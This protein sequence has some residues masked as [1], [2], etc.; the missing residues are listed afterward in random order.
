MQ[1]VMM[2]MLWSGPCV[3]IK[4]VSVMW[5]CHQSMSWTA[6]GIISTMEGLDLPS[7]SPSADIKVHPCSP[8]HGDFTCGGLIQGLMK[9]ISQWRCGS[10]SRHATEARV[11]EE[12]RSDCALQGHRQE[13]PPTAMIYASA[14]ARRRSGWTCWVRVVTSWAINPRA[15]SCHLPPVSHASTVNLPY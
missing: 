11:V 14:A 2:P 4:C 15:V 7:P 3:H 5:H 1:C 8:A 10:R 6:W 9:D 13:A 12:A